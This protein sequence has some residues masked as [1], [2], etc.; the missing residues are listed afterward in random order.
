MASHVE[1]NEKN[2]MIREGG[3]WSSAW[4]VAGFVG[5]LGLIGALAGAFS[6]DSETARR[7]A[8]SYVF[9]YFAFLT[10]A[11]GGLFFVLIQRL[12]SA[13][14]SVTVRRVAEFL[15]SGLPV[16]AALALPIL[17]NVKHFDWYST[18]AGKPEGHASILENQAYA[19]E[20]PAPHA[21]AAP[22]AGEHGAA[23]AAA[24]H[25]AAPSEHAAEAAH[26][27]H[28]EHATAHEAHDPNHVAHLETLEKKKGW[29]SLN[30]FYGRAMFYILAWVV[31]GTIFFNLSVKQDKT[32]SPALTLQ[33]QKYAPVAMMAFALSLTFSAFD[34]VMAL[35]PSWFST[36]FGVYVFATA[37]VSSIAVIILITMSLRDA[38]YLKNV[39]NVEH[40]HDLGKLLFGFNVFWAYIGFSQFLLIWYAGLP[41]ETTYYHYRWDSSADPNAAA[42]GWAAFS[43]FLLVCHFVVPFFLL[44]SRNVKRKLPS[45]KMGA[46]WLLVM[47]LVDWYWF[48][49]PNFTHYSFEFRWLDVACP[50]AVGG[51][52]FGY[53]FFR[54][55]KHALIPVGDPRIQRAIHFQNA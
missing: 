23:P 22:A 6:S 38:G 41:E 17:V 32:K 21:V 48:V 40:F 44:L 30:F 5:V 53:V 43:L 31:L 47:H 51:I 24:A 25:G 55:T 50:M 13:G 45:L 28:E 52:Y 9:A 18:V 16:M 1:I 15:A 49:M 35:D 12:T 7:F 33:A 37:A 3:P 39:V 36:I 27:G 8:Y 14:W 4:K 46:A 10:I 42:G 26:A 2:F 11:L 20:H 54:M 34:W 19:E 29:F